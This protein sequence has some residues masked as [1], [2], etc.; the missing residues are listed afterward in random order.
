MI[1]IYKIL[2]D[3]KIPFIR[4]DHPAVFTAGEAE[5]KCNDIPGGH[6][7]NLFLRNRKGDKHYLVIVDLQKQIDLKQPNN[8]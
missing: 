6:I 4:Y 8:Q 2:E 1:D 3:Q 5:E 7:K